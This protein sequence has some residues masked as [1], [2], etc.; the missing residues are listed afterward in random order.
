[1]TVRGRAGWRE[2]GHEQERGGGAP[3]ASGDI[4]IAVNGKPVKSTDLYHRQIARWAG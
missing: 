1:M 3:R 2:E 4:I